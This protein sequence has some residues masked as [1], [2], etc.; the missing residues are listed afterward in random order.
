MALDRGEVEGWALEFKHPCKKN[1]KINDT[2]MNELST[3][4]TS[5]YM[6]TI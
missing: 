5:V 2:F 4:F 6:E 3:F 1:V